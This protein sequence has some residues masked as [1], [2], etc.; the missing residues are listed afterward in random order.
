MPKSCTG[1]NFPIFT[2]VEAYFWISLE[3]VTN[4]GTI[5]AWER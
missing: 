1:L 5:L 3:F 4:N 2:I